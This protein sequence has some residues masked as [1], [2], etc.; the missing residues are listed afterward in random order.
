M[1]SEISK[2]SSTKFFF[3]GDFSLDGKPNILISFQK[4]PKDIAAAKINIKMLLGE[5]PSNYNKSRSNKDIIVQCDYCSSTYDIYIPDD[6]V[7]ICAN[8]PLLSDK[9]DL[10][11]EKSE[12]V[13][14]V[15]KLSGI[16][17]AAA[18]V[19][20]PEDWTAFLLNPSSIINRY[21]N[22]PDTEIKTLILL[23][24]SYILKIHNGR[25]MYCG[26]G[27]T[28]SKPTGN[29]NGGHKGLHDKNHSGKVLS[30]PQGNLLSFGFSISVKKNSNSITGVNQKPIHQSEIR[31][32]LFQFD[33]LDESGMSRLMSRDQEHSDLIAG[34]LAP[35]SILLVGQLLIPEGRRTLWRSGVIRVTSHAGD[36]RMIIVMSC[37]QEIMSNLFIATS[38]SLSKIDGVRILK[39]CPVRSCNNDDLDEDS[40]NN[41]NCPMMVLVC[42][43][44]VKMRIVTMRKSDY[45]SEIF[46]QPLNDDLGHIHDTDRNIIL[47][48]EFRPVISKTSRCFANWMVELDPSTI[49]TKLEDAPCEYVRLITIF[50]DLNLPGTTSRLSL[51]TGIMLPLEGIEQL[52]IMVAGKVV[53]SEILKNWI[54]SMLQ[55]LQRSIDIFALSRSLSET[56][57]TDAG[58]LIRTFMNLLSV[59]PNPLVPS[60]T[61]SSASRSSSTGS[62]QDLFQFETGTPAQRPLVSFGPPAD[63]S[64]V[65]QNDP[66]QDTSMESIIYTLLKN[67]TI[68]ELHQLGE[69]FGF[70]CI[71]KT[72][73]DKIFQFKGHKQTVTVFM[74]TS[75][76]LMQPG[77]SEYPR[78]KI[79]HCRVKDLG[80]MLESIMSTEKYRPAAVFPIFERAKRKRSRSSSPPAKKRKSRVRGDD[81]YDIKVDAQSSGG[82]RGSRSSRS[83]RSSRRSSSPGYPRRSKSSNTR[84]PRNRSSRRSRSQRR[85][86]D[87]NSR[88]SASSTSQASKDL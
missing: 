27:R 88:S 13:K 24:Q 30:N 20:S 29:G 32:L 6:I 62:D 23:T 52:S 81:S 67:C 76:A 26:K 1:K 41:E 84:R 21:L 60:P 53:P 45:L 36:C 22:I 3:P 2:L 59:S 11:L 85:Y 70:S 64:P 49:I 14:T 31:N 79:Q 19:N 82:S 9:D 83:S 57:M 39:I 72:T 73:R 47:N 12:I 33:N 46:L 66:N 56:S 4:S 74:S 86:E 38:N 34:I 10:K 77:G 61:S 54:E 25:K 8:C 75:T 51:E 69:T 48:H 5:Y 87:R 40:I 55:M 80:I 50:L 7:H 35:K 17:A 42:R 63:L 28:G 18:L 37:Y 44:P 43:Y 71:D 65:I 58:A 16:N 68:A 78:T 15:C